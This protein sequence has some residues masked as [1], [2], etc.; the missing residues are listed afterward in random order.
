[1]TIDI[2]LKRHH[3]AELSA[4]HG[5]EQL[6]LKHQFV[7]ITAQ[8]ALALKPRGVHFTALRFSFEDGRHVKTISADDLFAQ[9]ERA[10]K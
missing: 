6:T 2:T 10:A 8:T 3:R 9:V 7:P 1:M 5:A 4:W